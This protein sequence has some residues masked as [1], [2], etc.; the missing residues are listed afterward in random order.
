MG[1]AFEMRDDD[2]ADDAADDAAAAAA[3]VCKS[4]SSVW[5]GAATNARDRSTAPPMLTQVPV[6]VKHV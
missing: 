4:F 3:R 1:R 6:G 5:R 2:G